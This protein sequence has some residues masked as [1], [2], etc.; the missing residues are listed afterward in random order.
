MPLTS[1]WARKYLLRNVREVEEFVRLHGVHRL[2][3]KCGPS[4][5][6]CRPNPAKEPTLFRRGF[7]EAERHVV[8][9]KRLA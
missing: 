9:G 6:T 2:T 8:F 1:Y 5:T 7:E 4:A 3:T